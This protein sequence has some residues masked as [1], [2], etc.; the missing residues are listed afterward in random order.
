MQLSTKN[1]EE[2]IK[3]P[4]Y[5]PDIILAD[6][7]GIIAK[8]QNLVFAGHFAIL[9]RDECRFAT[10][11]FRAASTVFRQNACSSASLAN[12]CAYAVPG[13]RE[14]ILTGCA[15]IRTKAFAAFASSQ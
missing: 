10:K 14:T 8:F 1:F 9:L 5:K 15:S 6:T 12:S 4:K 7:A 13:L 11:A 2:P 3:S